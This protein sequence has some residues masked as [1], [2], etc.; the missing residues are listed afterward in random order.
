MVVLLMSVFAQVVFRY[1]FV[2]PL[3]WSEEL[4]RYTFVWV[5]MLGAAG[6]I[7]KSLTQ[8]IDILVNKLPT[9]VQVVLGLIIR[10]LIVAFCLLLIIKGY[11]LTKIT[12]I[13][14]SAVIGFP[15]SYAYFSVPFSAALMIIILCLDS[16]ITYKKLLEENR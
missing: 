15:M 12:H 14:K 13:Q 8:G 2:K 9:S 11:E 4:A 5:S 6:V 7:P 10:S 1:V 16:I 3:S